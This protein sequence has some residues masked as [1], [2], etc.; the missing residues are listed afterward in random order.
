LKRVFGEAES[1][2]ERGM[3]GEKENK[4]HQLTHTR[5][6]SKLEKLFVMELSLDQLRSRIVPSDAADGLAYFLLAKIS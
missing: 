3:D 1:A 6:L 2:M 4:Q 5:S